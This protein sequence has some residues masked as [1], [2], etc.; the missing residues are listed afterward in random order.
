[1]VMGGLVVTGE[2]EAIGEL[3]AKGVGVLVRE[4]STVFADG[5]LITKKAATKTATTSKGCCN[6]E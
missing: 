6:G 1:M 3:E 2:L 5:N 4:V